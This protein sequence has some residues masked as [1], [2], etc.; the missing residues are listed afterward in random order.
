[1]LKAKQGCRLSL[2][3]HPDILNNAFLFEQGVAN[4]DEEDEKAGD[5]AADVIDEQ[6]AY[7]YATNDEEDYME[8]DD[9]EDDEEENADEVYKW[10][11]VTQYK[12]FCKRFILL[13]ADYKIW[14]PDNSIVK[15]ICRENFI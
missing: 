15:D 3:P 6:P 12:L 1:M 8:D 10:G 2:D 7:L 9:D 4:H 11:A 13:V 14:A 5:E